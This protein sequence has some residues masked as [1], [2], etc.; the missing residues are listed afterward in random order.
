MVEQLMSTLGLGKEEAGRLLEAA[1]GKVEVAINLALDQQQQGGGMGAGAGKGQ[2]GGGG[3]GGRQETTMADP[4]C[5]QAAVAAPSYDVWDPNADAAS[6][7]GSEEDD[8]DEEEENRHDDDVGLARGE[9]I[10]GGSLLVRFDADDADIRQNITQGKV[11][12]P[13]VSTID[14]T[15]Q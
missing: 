7:C 10:Q 9:R 2:G 1:G 3:G 8:D 15:G 13:K 4:S 6:P 14:E 11:R 12:A 5:D